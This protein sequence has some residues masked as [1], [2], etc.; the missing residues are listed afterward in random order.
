MKRTNPRDHSDTTDTA[1]PSSPG[2]R[3][4]T[5]RDLRAGDR[6]RDE[7][8]FAGSRTVACVTAELGQ[9]LRPWYA[10]RFAGGDVRVADSLAAEVELIAAEPSRT[11]A[12]TELPPFAPPRSMAELI[13]LAHQHRRAYSVVHAVDNAEAPFVTFTAQW[14]P[15]GCEID[16]KVRATWHTRDTGRYRLFH[17]AAQGYHRGYH[18]VTLA[19]AYRLLTGELCFRRDHGRP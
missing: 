11:R 8:G 16:T 7:H 5:V 6:I 4:V 10:V 14:S 17:A 12:T 9:D 1:T 3:A 18:T 13:D 15:P 19:T 2:G